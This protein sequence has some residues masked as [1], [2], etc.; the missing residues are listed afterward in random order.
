MES[1]ER[2]EQFDIEDILREFSQ[3]DADTDQLLRQYF[4][5]TPM[6]RLPVYR[7]TQPC[8]E[9]APEPTLERTAVFAP[10]RQEQKPEEPEPDLGTTAPL[11]PIWVEQETAM[12]E[13][14][15]DATIEFEPVEQEEIPAEAEQ[16]VED[17][18]AFEAV[19]PAIEEEPTEQ[20]MPEAE[21]A[22]EPELTSVNWQEETEIQEEEG[23]MPPLQTEA[24]PFSEDWEPE[25]EEPMGEFQGKAPI[26]FP[27]KNR[28]R[29]LREKLVAG[30]EKRFHDLSAAGLH[31]LQWGILLQLLIVIFTVGS[32]VWLHMHAAKP[33]QVQPL[34]FSQL[35]AILLS[36][37]LG[38]YRLLNGVGSLLRGKFTLNTLLAVS[39][40]ACVADAYF[41]IQDQRMPLSALFCLQMLMS[42]W[43]AY[44]DRYTEM[45]QMDVLRKANE[46][47]ALV[48][49]EKY[50]D[51]KP[52]YTTVDGDPDD[53]MRH[54]AATGAPEK[55]LRRY[56]LVALIV[57]LFLALVA[58]LRF[59]GITGVQILAS[60]LL[61]GLPVTA[62]ISMTR[63]AAILQKRLRIHGAVLC[64]WQGVRHAEKNAVFPLESEDIFPKDSIKMSGVKYYGSV[65]PGWATACAAALARANGSTL[66][67]ILEQ[68][69]RG[70]DGMN[71]IVEDLGVWPGGVSGLVS[72]VPAALGT[73]EFMQQIQVE[74]PADVRIPY[75][76]YLAVEGE[77]CGVFAVSYHGAK[78]SVAGLRNLCGWRSLTPLVIGSDFMLT[79]RFIREKMGVKAQRLIFPDHAARQ[80]LAQIQ[81]GEDAPVVALTTNPGLAAR[82][83]AING[84]W[85]LRSAQSSGA[86]I[87]MLGGLLGLTLAALLS[88]L[89]AIE[90]L[91][92]SNLLLYTAV[93]ILPGLLSTEWTRH[94]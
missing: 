68:L 60:S 64:G 66:R 32:T 10:I 94:I 16:T 87:H 85:A 75:A 77:L 54:Y 17:T 7:S 48:K 42:Q 1:N 88:L 35:V 19:A 2:K 46:L 67:Y 4:S 49:I 39:F 41:C 86:N 92:P 76:V 83:Y 9:V 78:A 80:A 70:R 29:V 63:P 44:Q 18:V 51:N 58:A 59:N 57:S 73:A 3:K 72:G 69:P 8:R 34:L 12:P 61:I 33:T 74:I 30:P 25:Y 15:P 28:T 27:Q 53:F 21:E 56:A 13:S 82:T 5:E 81:P 37:L 79:P 71:Q 14:V 93:W 55:A 65:E 45:N 84:A 90:L 11:T 6:V 47:R 50:C 22:S 38:C 20:I 23:Q 36:G 89:G 24:E 40:V 26:V 31:G 52:G 62:H 43:S 91:S